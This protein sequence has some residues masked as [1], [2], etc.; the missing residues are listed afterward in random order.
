MKP[1]RRIVLCA[2]APVLLVA[3]A[4]LTWVENPT[5]DLIVAEPAAVFRVKGKGAQQALRLPRFKSILARPDAKSLLLYRVGDKQLEAR[6]FSVDNN[7]LMG[8]FIGGD[9][10]ILHVPIS[11]ITTNRYSLL[12]RIRA[13]SARQ[14]KL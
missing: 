10:Y 5:Q 4:D 3:C 9:S 7:R 1:I 2:S 13:V 12:C 8:D 6:N 14:S 11:H